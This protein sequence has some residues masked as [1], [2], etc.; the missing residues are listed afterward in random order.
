[1]QAFVFLPFF[2]T[3]VRCSLCGH[4]Q[5]IKQLL[6]SLLADGS[7]PFLSQKKSH[8]NADVGVSLYCGIV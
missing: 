5:L 3:T 4:D 1:M 6:D 2:A 8:R 7:K